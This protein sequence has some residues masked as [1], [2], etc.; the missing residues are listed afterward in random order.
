MNC[1]LIFP[2]MNELSNDEKTYLSNQGVDL[3]DWD[4]MLFLPPG[5]LELVNVTKENWTEGEWVKTTTP[6]WQP[7][8]DS[9]LHCLEIGHFRNTWK[10]IFFRGSDWDLLITHHA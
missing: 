8:S 3:D 1:I 4:F 5:N 10:K 7:K 9:P 2:E 6:T